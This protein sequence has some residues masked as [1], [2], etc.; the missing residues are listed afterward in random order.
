MTGGGAGRAVLY[1]CAARPRGPQAAE[2][3]ARREG[4]A[5]A[6]TEG[7]T[8]TETVIDAFG[9]ADPQDREGWQR[10]RGLAAR[11]E[12]DTVITRFPVSIAPDSASEARYAE[13]AGLGSCGVRVRYSW[14]ALTQAC[15][16]NGL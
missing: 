5:F 14:Q 12:V 8:I 9:V 7:L 2:E 4:E 10:V 6:A 15:V 3:R 16:G 11:G 1:V 13:I